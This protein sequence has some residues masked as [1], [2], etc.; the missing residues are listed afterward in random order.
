MKFTQTWMTTLEDVVKSR[1]DIDLTVAYY[2][3][4]SAYEPPFDYCG[5]HYY[6]VLN[7]GGSYLNKIR[8]RVET[9]EQRDKILLQRIVKVVEDVQPDII[10]IHGTECNFGLLTNVI[11]NIPIVISLQG[12][13]SPIVERY[14]AGIP[15][16]IA[17]ECDSWKDY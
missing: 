15:Q 4:M 8:E 17:A 3:D 5:V 12:I 16:N 1:Q 6:P 2:C 13:I 9:Q 7:K 14:Y 11:A 10:H